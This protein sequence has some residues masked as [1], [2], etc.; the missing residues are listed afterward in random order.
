MVENQRSVSV[1][2]EDNENCYGLP[3]RTYEALGRPSM[4]SQVKIAGPSGPEELH[5][6]TGWQ[7]DGDGTP[8][9]AYYV[10]VSD[11]GEGAAYLLYGGDWGV[12]FRP[13]DG[14]EE[15]RLESPEQ[16]G[17]P[18]LLLGDL[19]DIVAVEQ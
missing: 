15:W 16:W 9:P 5:W 7:S 18:Y 10:P 6:V 8:C 13:L 3:M 12:R 19:A 4:V 11:S 1:E 14:D 2:V 17:E